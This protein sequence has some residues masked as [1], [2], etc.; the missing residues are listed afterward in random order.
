MVMATSTILLLLEERKFERHMSIVHVD[1]TAYPR[2]KLNSFSCSD[3][4]N[5][6]VRMQAVAGVVVNGGKG[7]QISVYGSYSLGELDYPAPGSS[8]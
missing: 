7:S 1:L 6:K 8:E 3:K 5:N 4:F 2:N